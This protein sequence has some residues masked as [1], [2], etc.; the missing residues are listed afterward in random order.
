MKRFLKA[1]TIFAASLALFTAPLA[2]ADAN[3]HIF[4]ACNQSVQSSSVCKNQNTTTN[5]VVGKIKIAVDIVAIIAGMAAVIMAIISGLTMVGSGGSPE[6]VANARKQL[7]YA[8]VGIVV[9]ALA[10]AITRFVVDMIL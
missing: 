5:P 3:N 4:G 2:L 6:A 8:I 7:T 10:W 9:I 1:L